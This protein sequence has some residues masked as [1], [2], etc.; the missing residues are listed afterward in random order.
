MS[1]T[2]QSQMSMESVGRQFTTITSVLWWKSGRGW[3]YV[4]LRLLALPLPIVVVGLVGYLLSLSGDVLFSSFIPF[5]GL[6]WPGFSLVLFD[7]II[8]R[9]FLKQEPLL[10]GILIKK[11]HPIF[12]VVAYYIALGISLSQAALCC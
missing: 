1:E 3:M 6:I 5:F 7:R 2:I 4:A 11:V 8:D 12:F 9:I 10:K